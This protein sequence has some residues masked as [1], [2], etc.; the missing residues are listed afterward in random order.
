MKRQWLRKLPNI[1]RSVK[2][3]KKRLVDQ[4][5]TVHSVEAA[6][7][8]EAAEVVGVAEAVEVVV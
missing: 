3:K 7:A 5:G 2:Q 8:A 6:E 1:G 4:H